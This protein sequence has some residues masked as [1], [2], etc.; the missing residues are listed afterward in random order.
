MVIHAWERGR[1]NLP[2]VPTTMAQQ[3]SWSSALQF[4]MAAY[5]W[6]LFFP[7]SIAN[8][9][10]CVYVQCSLST[11][12]TSNHLFLVEVAPV[13]ICRSGAKVPYHETGTRSGTEPSLVIPI[14]KCNGWG[15]FSFSVLFRL[16]SKLFF[17][18]IYSLCTKLKN[19]VFAQVWRLQWLSIFHLLKS[20]SLSGTPLPPLVRVSQKGRN[21]QAHGIFCCRSSCRIFASGFGSI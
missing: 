7:F 6:D 16:N 11:I 13:P 17:L 14:S 18:Y 9:L 1:W 10:V 8:S 5:Q 21:I 3:L 20:M 4:L 15:P 12:K 2:S 19:A